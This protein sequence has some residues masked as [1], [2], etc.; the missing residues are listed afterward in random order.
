MIDSD[1]WARYYQVT[2]DRPSWETVRFA[3]ARFAAEASVGQRFAVDLGCGA[4]RDTRELLRGGW[5]VL[6][7]DR[8]PEAIAVL[9]RAVEPEARASVR[10]LVADLATV[11]I[12]DCDLVNASVS[13]P[14]LAPDAF[15]L[16]WSRALAALEIGGR[17]AAMLYG[18]RDD[19]AD[20]PSM[21]C[22]EPDA[23]RASLTGFEIEHWVD[24]EEDSQTALGEPHHFHRLDLVARRLR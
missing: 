5:Q 7:V 22:V 21:T 4:G 18:D 3:I 20:D 19:G 17:I 14:F 1:Y 2:M 16:T 6:A 24:I 9:E 12:P 13:L 23:V 15:W 10:T 11:E 8:E